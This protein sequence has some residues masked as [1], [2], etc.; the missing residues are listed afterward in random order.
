MDDNSPYILLYSAN[1][2]W[3]PNPGAQAVR[4]HLQAVQAGCS[5]GCEGVPIPAH[6]SALPTLWR[7]AKVLALGGV[8]GPAKQ[9]CVQTSTQ[10]GELSVPQ[11]PELGFQNAGSMYHCTN[12]MSWENEMGNET[13][14][15]VTPETF[16]AS[17]GGN[18]REQ[19]GVDLDLAEILGNT[20]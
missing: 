17:L 7:A 9:P 15:Q 13:R 4:R 1:E 19:E 11:K 14:E 3:V 16:L 12:I 6:R 8:L 5:G 10:A 18:L 20:F 2:F